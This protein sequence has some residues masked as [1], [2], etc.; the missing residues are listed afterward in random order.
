M[1]GR[2]EC[3]RL[4]QILMFKRARH[5]VISEARAPTFLATSRQV[6]VTDGDGWLEGR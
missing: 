5:R 3:Q 6:A 2:I 1:M 4:L